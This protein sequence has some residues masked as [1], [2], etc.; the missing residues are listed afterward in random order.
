MAGTTQATA[1]QTLCNYSGSTD[2]ALRRAAQANWA[3]IAWTS[4]GGDEMTVASDLLTRI[5]TAGTNRARAAEAARQIEAIAAR[6][7]AWEEELAADYRVNMAKSDC[8]E[9]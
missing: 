7:R 9:I 3:Y 4:N 8:Y 5:A 6:L 2:E 1:T